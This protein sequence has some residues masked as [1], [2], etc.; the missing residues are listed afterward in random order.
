MIPLETSEVSEWKYV[1]YHCL[2]QL[3]Q[4]KSL[5][6]ISMDNVINKTAALNSRYHCRKTQ[7]SLLYKFQKT[8]VRKFRLELS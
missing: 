1:K 3:K 5:K 6:F 7:V 8:L 4:T 2:Q